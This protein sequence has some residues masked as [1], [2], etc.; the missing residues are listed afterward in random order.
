MFFMAM[1]MLVMPPSAIA[2]TD[3]FPFWFDLTPSLADGRITVRLDI[4]SRTDWRVDDVTISVPI[5][6]G[7]RFLSADVLPINRMWV[8]D[9]AVNIRLADVYNYAD[10]NSFTLEITDPRQTV[11]P[12]TATVQW[13]G[14]HPG[15]EQITRQPFDTT[16][17][18]LD[19][20]LSSPRLH[21]TAAATI[22]GSTLALAVYPKA[23]DKTFRMWDARISIPVPDGLVFVS[24]DAPQPFSAKF[25][26]QTVIFSAIEVPRLTDLPPLVATFTVKNANPIAIKIW[27]QWM[28]GPRDPVHSGNFPV[29]YVET[30][31]AEPLPPE[32]EVFALDA[33]ISQPKIPQFTVFDRTG[34]VPF[35]PYDLT[36]LSFLQFE[37]GTKL[38][39]R[40]AENTTDAPAA[41]SLYVDRDCDPN[42]G[43][44]IHGR[45]AEYRINFSADTN[46]ATVVPWGSA[47]WNWDAGTEQSAERAGNVTT[48]AFPYD[49]VLA[50]QPFCWVASARD[51]T[52]RYFPDPPFDWLPDGSA[53]E[54]SR[55]QLAPPTFNGTQ[56]KIAVPLF[57]S[58]GFYDTYF[59]SPFAGN[60]VAQ[61]PYA[62]QPN[63]SP[64]GRTLL[65]N[66]EQ[67]SAQNRVSY[68]FWDG[69]RVTF[70]FKN[71]SSAEKIFEYS[72]AAK[73]ETPASVDAR[74]AYPFYNPQGTAFVFTTPA[75]DSTPVLAIRPAGTPP[76]PGESSFRVLTSAAEPDGVRGNFPVW[77][78]DGRVA[79]N[80][81]AFDTHRA[82]CGIFAIPTDAPAAPVWLSVFANDV[83]ADASVTRLVFTSHRD[84]NW[85]AY[86]MADD[87]TGVK[88]L[89]NAPGNDGLPTFSPDGKWVAFASDRDGRWAVWVVPVDGGEP[90]KL[91]TLPDADPWATGDSAWVRERMS[92]SP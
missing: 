56:G 31:T 37:N 72:V 51:T 12:L 73:T 67:F 5:P 68:T 22:A 65:V 76:T 8:V 16:R 45:G 26:G 87:G 7:T 44:A 10:G 83:P 21:V 58:A 41:F 84:G 54:T 52:T 29:Q 80:P 78:G 47:D 27:V 59:F 61:I 15:S 85:E 79:F 19:W 57:N 36:A 18:P 42:T 71:F 86:V 3:D 43:T 32:Q 1:L 33:I 49:V 92:W 66:H 50:G 38:Q 46:Y 25:D 20:E 6:A 91:F 13:H 77:L 69:R 30:D 39:F 17:T 48:I 74:D 24:T 89:S 40:T 11:F 2:Q 82:D 4:S 90:Q 28:N 70:V 75:A 62:R 23:I 35:A 55:Y 60:D 34:D 88:N 64:D 14:D 81:C 63:F 53:S 9:N